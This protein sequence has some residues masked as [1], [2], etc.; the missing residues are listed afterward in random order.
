M[1]HKHLILLS[2][3]IGCL[4][5]FLLSTVTPS[6]APAISPAAQ[7][8]APIRFVAFGDYGDNSSA[9][10]A[11]A[12]LVNSLNPDFIITLGDNSY[13]S[14]N[15]DDN[16]GQH[17][18]DYIGAYSGTYDLG[19][20]T[21]RFFPALGNHDYGDGGGLDAY[22]AYFTLPGAGV[23]SSNTSGNERYYDFIQGP[24]HFFAI[25][26][27][28]DETDGHTSTSTQ[29][30]WLQA[31]LA[32]STAPWKIVYM[33]HPPYSSSSA[34]GSETVMQWPYEAWGATAVLAGHDHTYE[35][36]LRDDNNDGTDLVY[37]VAGLGGKSRYAF[38]DSDFV[39][40][41]Q[42]RY[43][44][45]YG[46]MLVEACA[47]RI[48][49]SFYSL[50]DGLVDTY[51]L[52]ASACGEQPVGGVSGK[53]LN[54]QD[55]RVNGATVSVRD[56]I[57]A[58]FSSNGGSYSLPTGPGTFSLVAATDNGWHSL[59]PITRTIALTESIPLTFTLSPP[60]NFIRNGGFEGNLDGWVSSIPVTT[61][62]AENNRSGNYSLGISQS[63]ILTQTDQVTSMYRPV[64]SFWYK[65]ENGDGQDSLVVRIFGHDNLVATDPLTLT[66]PT[67][68]WQHI[69][70][71]LVL[72][73]TIIQT[74]TGSFY[75]GTGS[76]LLLSQDVYSGPLGVQYVVN[77]VDLTPTLFY[78][79]EVTFGR[80]WGGPNRIYLP[81][82]IKNAL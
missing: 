82:M 80:S 33:H 64:L 7:L 15:I 67:S 29:A 75:P 12:A 25:N 65:V 78:L 10:A 36:I 5:A 47:E 28:A 81:I 35:R 48:T 69:S 61:F 59:E 41:S 56:T 73:Y 20:V 45:D 34:H 66:N 60:D 44:D 40:G 6:P 43:R 27:N 2:T 42:I 51:T 54:N 77:Q 39:P 16:I 37:F 31:Q 4:L 1:R 57:T 21:N 38:P 14:N 22:L 30:Q 23:S 32:A 58:T 9:E 50:S 11:V 18:H 17:Y 24:V 52:G 68:S 72:S 13:G 49:F 70:L 55:N 26:S 53:V 62:S 79:D 19:A 76:L 3:L 46:T 63:I 8:S 71:P 74:G